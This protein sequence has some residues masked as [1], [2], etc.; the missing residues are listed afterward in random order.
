MKKLFY[1]S[2]IFISGSISAQTEL[3]NTIR[4]TGTND[5]LREVKNL[6][7]STS[8]TDLL[9]ASTLQSGTGLFAVATGTDSL[10]L[11]LSV[12]ID[13]LRPG[14]LLNILCPAVNTSRVY[15]SEDSVAYTELLKNGN[16]FLEAGD[17]KPGQIITVVFDGTNFQLMSPVNRSCPSG[18]VKVNERY[19]IETG[20][21]AAAT[22]F[23]AAVTCGDMGAHVCNW[24]EWY[25]A[26]QKSGLGL[27]N[28]TNNYEFVDTP[29]NSDG[30]LRVVG[31]GTC[32]TAGESFATTARA[33]RCCFSR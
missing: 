5:T 22:F 19:C 26:C 6:S 24:S 18:M 2:L 15:I 21:R 29:S 11:S 16:S 33:F 12:G 28:M 8:E 25:F 23:V 3:N 17:I 32:K 4:F 13:S 7:R 30:V 9:N 14:L 31:N 1:I 27:S 10:L 20:E